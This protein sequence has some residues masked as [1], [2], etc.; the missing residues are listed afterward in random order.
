MFGFRNVT[1]Q[2]FRDF[3]WWRKEF[4]IPWIMLMEKNIGDG[5]IY[6]MIWF[7]LKW[8]AREIIFNGVHLHR[9]VHNVAI[10]S[11]W[12]QLEFTHCP[13]KTDHQQY[14]A[15]SWKAFVEETHWGKINVWVY[16]CLANI[17]LGWNQSPCLD[18]KGLVLKTS[19]FCDLIWRDI[20]RLRLVQVLHCY[21]FGTK[22]FLEPVAT[23]CILDG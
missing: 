12:K 4:G 9:I 16:G 18:F 3:W 22:P 11:R 6:E 1:R 13:Q 2:N 10:I 19:T 20:F 8:P 14:T 7:D 21:L 17:T 23:F 5:K 15:P